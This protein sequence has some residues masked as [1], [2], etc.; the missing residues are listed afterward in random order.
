MK[1]AL[2]ISLESCLK[3]FEKQAIPGYANYSYDA[4]NLIITY[5]KNTFDLEYINYSGFHIRSLIDARRAAYIYLKES[6]LLLPKYNQTKLLTV[7]LLFKDISDLLQNVISYNDLYISFN[8]IILT[9]E[10]REQL[11]KTLQKTVNLEKQIRIMV[12]DILDNW[13]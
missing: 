8:E 4:Y 2:K 9:V 3:I 11:V 12:K 7:A 13:K 10:I 6:S 1:D 5:L